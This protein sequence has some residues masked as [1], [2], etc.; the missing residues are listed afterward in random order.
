MPIKPF[1]RIISVSIAAALTLLI[2]CDTEDPVPANEE[3]LI[4]TV[5]LTFQKMEAGQPSGGPEIFTWKD[6]DG[7]GPEEPVI[8]PVSLD[9]HSTYNLTIALL[10]ES[11]TPV[12]NVTDEVEEEGSAHQFF[13]QV[14]GV[15][16]TSEYNDVDADG[17]PLGISHTISTDH[18]GTGT[19]T[20]ILIH[21]PDKTAAGVAN[22]DPTNAGGETDV[23]ARFEVTILE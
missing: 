20:V 15:D 7:S 22:G 21:E 10:N 9:A 11:T 16:I 3:E 5:K 14:E 23:Q 17:K 13:I 2:S 18:S 1:C 6:D 19:L 12:T 8:V 4:T